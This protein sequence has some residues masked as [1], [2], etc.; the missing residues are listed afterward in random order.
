MRV[1]V[2]LLTL[3]LV[4][5]AVPAL[6]S[7]QRY[8]VVIAQGR[9]IDPE[10]GLD[11][12]RWVGIK[13]GRIA[14]LST[15]PL[16]GAQ[17]I[18]AHGLV[19]A[20]GFIDLHQHGQDDE[21]YRIA[22]LDGVTTA[23]E[24]EV[25]TNDVERWYRQRATGQRINYGVAI[26]H[27][28]VR[29]AVLGDSG[30]FLPSGPAVKRVATA[31][32]IAEMARRIDLGLRQGAVAVGFGT[33][34]TPAASRWEILDMFRVAGRYGASCHIHIR[35][36]VIG[37]EEAITAAAISGAPLHIVHINSVSLGDIAPMLQLVTDARAHHLDVT[38]EAYP[39]TAGAT[40]I[41][42]ALF[43]DWES[44]R[45][46]TF[47]RSSGWRPESGSPAR[48]SCSGGRS[49]AWSSFTAILRRT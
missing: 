16:Q 44:S 33:A 24:L 28:P 29:M 13:D 36:G 34:Y 37:A 47:R 35:D 10:S 42:S 9:V 49:A 8:D 4:M 25:G 18:D 22:S 48:R 31:A 20:P 1:V 7:A 26:G 15:Q 23:L 45:T 5:I 3:G 17:S 21:N 40:M 6:A 19:V 11:A 12:T 14:A 38:T 46:R 2:R 39:Y 32:E 30:S 41:E 43:D 27:I